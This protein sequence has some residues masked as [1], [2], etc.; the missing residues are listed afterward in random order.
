MQSRQM[1][2]MWI[3]PKI[4][5]RSIGLNPL[6]CGDPM[7]LLFRRVEEL[8]S[9]KDVRWWLGSSDNPERAV[10]RGG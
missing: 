3:D 7:K 9:A 6:K 8:V 5:P 4:D 10:F 1:E 2:A